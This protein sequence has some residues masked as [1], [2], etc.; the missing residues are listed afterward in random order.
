M[1]FSPYTYTNL[2]TNRL[3][4]LFFAHPNVIEIYKKHPKVVLL[5][6]TY[7]TNRF[8]MP[9][10]NICAVTGNRKTIQ[11]A[12]CFL[13]SEKELDYEQAMSKFEEVITT[14][15]I[16]KLDTWVTDRELALMN[17]LDD[18][19]PNSNHLLCTQHVNIN[20]LANC[21]KYY[22]ADLRDLLKK[23]SANP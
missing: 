12:L 23:T 7:K 13:S 2:K 15:E 22:L 20:I 6:C 5:D 8:R 9:L 4:R 16:P 17:T 1:G 11:V 18:M 3:E 14:H 21:R 10:L 19:F